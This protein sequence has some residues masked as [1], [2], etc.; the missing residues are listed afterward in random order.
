MVL[1][2]KVRKRK[3]SIENKQIIQRLTEIFHGKKVKT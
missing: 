2:E 3:Q 1:S